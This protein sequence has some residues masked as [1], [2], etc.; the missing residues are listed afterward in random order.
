MTE[1]TYYC[2]R[3]QGERLWH[4]ITAA[5][6]EAACKL[7]SSDQVDG[8]KKYIAISQ[9]RV[10]EIYSVP[11]AAMENFTARMTVNPGGVPQ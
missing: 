6:Y 11:A 8:I 7:D 2:E 3:F 1:K 9:L 10:V 4:G 5:A